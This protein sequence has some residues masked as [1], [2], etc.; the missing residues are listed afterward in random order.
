[1]MTQRTPDLITTLSREEAALYGQEFLAPLTV[2]GRVRLRLRGLIYEFAVPNARPGWWVGQVR[3]ARQAEVV[4]AALPW[5]IDD[6]LALWPALR[7][8]L[9]EPLKH[10]AW[11]ALPVNPSDAARRFGLAGPLVVQLVEG[12]QPFERV[13]G[14]VE[15]RTLWYDDLDRRADPAMAEAL[16]EAFAS[17]REGP[18]V[19]NLGAGERAAYALLANRQTTAAPISTAPQGEHAL[20]MSGDSLRGY[21]ITS[22]GVRV[23]WEHERQRQ[24]ALINPDMAVISA[25]VGLNGEDARFDLASVVG[26]VQDAPGYAHG[27]DEWDDEPD[28]TSATSD[29]SESG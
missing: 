26:V 24:V 20:A 2:G 1:M 23:T 27:Y 7:L 17:G 25:G 21:E 8:V 10:R 16:R 4:E 3:S 13:I 19:A 14:R 12:G 29:V 15:G 18:G 11:L 6:Y 22:E 9:L 28:D 5:Q